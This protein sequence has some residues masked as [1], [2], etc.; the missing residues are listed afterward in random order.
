MV[1]WVKDPV[2]SLQLLGLLQRYR[3]DSQPG[4][5]GQGSRVA[6]AVA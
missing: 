2:L 4:I 1:Q 5:V 6:T 3:F